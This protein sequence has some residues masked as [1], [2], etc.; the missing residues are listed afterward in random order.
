MHEFPE[1]TLFFMSA[2]SLWDSRI[3]PKYLPFLIFARILLA[4]YAAENFL[5]FY[6]CSKSIRLHVEMQ[7]YFYFSITKSFYQSESQL[8]KIVTVISPFITGWFLTFFSQ[9]LWPLTIAEETFKE[10]FK[11]QCASR[12]ILFYIAQFRVGFA[13][14]LLSL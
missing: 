3:L 4:R 7:K 6:G 12:R 8:A 2:L 1:M 11:P 9:H 5:L 10:N 13:Q 14:I